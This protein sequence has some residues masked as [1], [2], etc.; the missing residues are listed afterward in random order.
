M[1]LYALSES[2]VYERVIAW[3]C[4]ENDGKYEQTCREHRA[5]DKRRLFSA[6]RLLEFSF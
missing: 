5:Y 1:N 3:T 4:K 2:E 6:I